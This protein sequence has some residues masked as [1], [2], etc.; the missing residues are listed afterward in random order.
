MVTMFA[1]HFAS[2]GALIAVLREK[3]I[4]GAPELELLRA[5]SVSAGPEKDAFL[6][7]IRVQYTG[8][9]KILG[10]ELDLDS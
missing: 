7:A 1:T 10:V 4:I 6:S 3:G 9:A 5:D 2:M 8:I